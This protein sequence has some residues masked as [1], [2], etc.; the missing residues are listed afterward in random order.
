MA[1]DDQMN[2]FVQWTGVPGT[3]EPVVTPAELT[4]TFN[5]TKLYAGLRDDAFFFDL[6]GFRETLLE[7]GNPTT[8]A[9]LGGMRGIRFANERNHF[10]RKN[11]SALAIEMPIAGAL[12]MG[13]SIRVWGTT[14]RITM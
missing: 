12:G 7:A 2:C 13:T 6:Q 1:Q 5:G 8:P 14:A 3:T 4:R 10:A 9:G 11:T